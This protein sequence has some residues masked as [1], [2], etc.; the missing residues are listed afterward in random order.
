VAAENVPQRVE[1]EQKRICAVN[2]PAQDD[3]NPVRVVS[4]SGLEYAYGPNPLRWMARV[5]PWYSR[6]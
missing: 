1:C 6:V 3:D 5:V 2:N 4:A